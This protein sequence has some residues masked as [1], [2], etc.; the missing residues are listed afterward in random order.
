MTVPA[1]GESQSPESTT[2]L[3]INP[4]PAILAAMWH[5]MKDVTS[6]AKGSQ[7]AEGQTRY[8]FRSIDDLL[9]DLGSAFRVRGV[10]AQSEQLEFHS[11][12]D[13][14]TRNGAPFTTVRV[15]MRYRWTSLEDGSTLVFEAWGEGADTADKA[16]MKA[17]TMALKAAL[18]QAFMLPTDEK[19]PDSVR[20]GDD[21]G[22]YS[23]PVGQ[24]S[25]YDPNAQA[26]QRQQA[27][28]QAARD[29]GVQPPKADGTREENIQAH[30]GW[31]QRE[32]VAG[33][34]LVRLAYI[35][36]ITKQRQ[37]LEVDAG[38]VPLGQRIKACLANHGI[39]PN[40]AMPTP[41]Q[42]KAYLEQQAQGGQE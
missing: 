32:L 23:A 3:M 15:K 2:N 12:R 4:P 35:H 36:M 39:D 40:R 24:G 22:D 6:V 19:D 10:F 14:K 9:K 34:D 31:V 7:Y 5:V 30:I 11:D 16:T 29:A 27:H 42:A 37:L 20:P 28:A 25:G 21:D 26:R 41:E 8:K 18:G 33:P 1:Q 17:Q 13:R 38:G